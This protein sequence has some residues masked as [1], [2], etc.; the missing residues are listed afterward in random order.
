[1]RV[2]AVKGIFF[3]VLHSVTLR[4]ENRA[5]TVHLLALPENQ[6]TI[7]L[8]C[9]GKESVLSRGHLRWFSDYCG[10][11]TRQPPS[12][13]AKPAMVA[14]DYGMYLWGAAEQSG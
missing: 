11:I 4:A 9:G 5:V 2:S 8:K 10:V 14:Q 6:S 1:M 12:S 13:R 3:V 7:T